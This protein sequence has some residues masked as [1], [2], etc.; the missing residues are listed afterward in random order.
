MHASVILSFPNI[1][2]TLSPHGD[3][4]ILGVPHFLT[5]KDKQYE[6]ATHG[7]VCQWGGRQEPMFCPRLCKG[8]ESPY[9]AHILKASEEVLPLHP[10]LSSL[11]CYH[12]SSC[13][14]LP[15][16]LRSGCGRLPGTVASRNR[17]LGERK[18][19]PTAASSLQ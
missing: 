9:L 16:L 5:L 13:Q 11:S 14:G 12:G 8:G 15:W 4:I 3:V 17:T 6:V 2:F 19:T 18:T 10:M 1:P 7:G